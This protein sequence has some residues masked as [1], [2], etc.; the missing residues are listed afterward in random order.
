MN[1]VLSPGYKSIFGKS[2]EKYEDFL[3]A[4]PSNAILTVLIAL[5]LELYGPMPEIEKQKRLIKMIAARFSLSQRQLLDNAY[6]HYRHITNGQFQGHY[7][8]RRYLLAMIVKEL[9]RNEQGTSDGLTPEQ[10]FNIFK[11]YLLAVDEVN[12]QDQQ[13]YSLLKANETSPLIHLR[14]LWIQTNQFQFNDQGNPPYQLFKV[15]CLGKFLIDTY[16]SEMR[17]YLHSLGMTSVGNLIHSFVQLASTAIAVEK[18]G[19]LSK[20]RFISPGPGVNTA[21]L[22]SIC[23]NNIIGSGKI[24]P[25]DLKQRPLYRMPDERYI[26]M[27]IAMLHRKIYMGPYFDFLTAKLKSTGISFHKYSSQV[28]K[29]V[30]EEKCFKAIVSMMKKGN[31]DIL[32]F[33]DGSDAS[34]DAYYRFGKTIFLI[35]FKGYL[36][37]EELS[38]TLDFDAFKT[39]IDQRFIKN[40]D[41]NAK[42]ITQVKTYLDRL[43]AREYTFDT[44]FVDEIYRNNYVVVPIICFDEYTFT[45]PGL[46]DYLSVCFRNELSNLNLGRVTV[47]PLTMISLSTLFELFTRNAKFDT[48]VKLVDRYWAILKGRAKKLTKHPSEDAFVRAFASFDELYMTIFEQEMKTDSVNRVGQLMDLAGVS[49][50]E[51][52]S[53]L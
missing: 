12:D 14:L 16:R 23:I 26:V 40:A 22:E 46:N 8:G 32:H 9:N 33:D 1:I 6:Q 31:S 45:L 21:H 53:P 13:A 35:E 50:D 11:A 49:E 10:E 51:I 4:V 29:Q 24:F 25:L 44:K 41:G 19:E 15:S 48:L 43:M 20:V 30:L 7:F 3:S 38:N 36:L 17:E 39:F 2:D 5:N 37:R 52:N 18:E 27:D 42:G 34:P 47:K 28:S